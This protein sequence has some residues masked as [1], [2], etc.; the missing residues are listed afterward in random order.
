M[1]Q[2]GIRKIDVVDNGLKAVEAVDKAVACAS[3]YDVILMDMQM[4]V[5][6]GL[7]ACHIIMKKTKEPGYTAAIPKVVFV[8]AQVSQ[9]FQEEVCTGEIL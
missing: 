1:Q 8:T 2:L 4:P 3:C 7:E 6:D 5:M 9:S